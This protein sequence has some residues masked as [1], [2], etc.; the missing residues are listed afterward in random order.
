MGWRRERSR[1]EKLRLVSTSP[2]E[3]VAI[4]RRLASVLR[5]GDVV[6]LEGDLGSGKT[7]L[8][9]GLAEGLGIEETVT[10]P[11]FVLVRP[12]RGGRLLLWHADAYRIGTKEAAD[13]GLEDIAE[14]GVLVIEW[15]DRVKAALPPPVLRIEIGQDGT[16]SEKRFIH[17][18]VVADEARFKGLGEELVGA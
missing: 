3:T 17:I 11:T 16:D 2:E 12:Y 15:A 7:T 5:E 14:D 6:Y 4:G 13:L 9:K 10:S 1:R 8:V 18:E